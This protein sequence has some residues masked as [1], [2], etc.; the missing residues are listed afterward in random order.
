[1][2]FRS[3]WY[4]LSDD[5]AKQLAAKI[6]KGVV[7]KTGKSAPAAPRPTK[8]SPST[9]YKIDLPIMQCGFNFDLVMIAGV[10]SSGHLINS[11]PLFEQ[12]GPSTIDLGYDKQ[13]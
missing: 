10:E 12:L 2:L 4:H 5:L 7:G 9:L 8:N 3:H 11:G 13:I 1:M 6:R